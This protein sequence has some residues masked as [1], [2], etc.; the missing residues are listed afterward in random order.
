MALLN[1]GVGSPPPTAP[2]VAGWDRVVDAAYDAI[3][4]E[5]GNGMRS[6]PQFKTLEYGSY[7]FRT[8]PFGSYD[9][10]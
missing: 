1:P 2:N 9:I 10:H 4:R 3:G 5:V 7:T 6:L 8:A